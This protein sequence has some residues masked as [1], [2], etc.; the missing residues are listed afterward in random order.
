VGQGLLPL[1]FH[2]TSKAY[3]MDNDQF[4]ILLE[5]VTD[6]KDKLDSLHG[7]FREFKGQQQT[8][9]EQLVKDSDSD[10]LWGRIQ[11]VAVIPVVA[12]IHAFA[13]HKGWIK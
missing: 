10:R 9:V 2:D 5:A 12:A 8:K 7:D 1:H 4:T 6:T 11:T 3:K 13:N